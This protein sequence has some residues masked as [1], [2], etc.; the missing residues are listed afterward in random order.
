MTV[1]YNTNFTHNPNSYLTLAVLDAAKAL[2]GPQ[3]VLADNRSLVPIAAAGLHDVLICIDGQRLHE[4]LLRRVRRSFRTVVLW[5]FEDP[6]MLEYNLQHAELFD[7]IFTNDP[8]CVGAY[9]GR[10]HYLPLAASEKFHRRP[11]KDDAELDYD[12]FFAGTM[13]PNRIQS[14]RRIINAFPDARLKLVCPT[15]EYLPPL[16]SDLAR[17]AIQWPV[18]HESF[19][20]FANASRVTLTMFRD[21]ASHGD[22]GQ[23]TAPGPRL[24]ELG[25]SGT[26]QVVKSARVTSRMRSSRWV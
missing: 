24:Y 20:D 1:I 25:L 16:P 8:A 17:L 5:L 21:Y 23:A 19:I 11:V 10:G 22:V 9:R 18:S 14:L 2:F 4:A 3:V 7:F 15:N 12:I 13:W 6:F 26:A